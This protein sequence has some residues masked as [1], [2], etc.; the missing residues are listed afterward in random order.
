MEMLLAVHHSN[1][2]VHVTSNE[3]GTNFK[4]YKMGMQVSCDMDTEV[5]K[6]DI[7]YSLAFNTSTRSS[8]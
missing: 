4:T 6:E 5:S 2:A 8:W 3:T 1:I 7:N